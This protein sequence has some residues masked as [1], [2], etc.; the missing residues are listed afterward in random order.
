MNL[1]ADQNLY[2]ERIAGDIKDTVTTTG[3]GGAI[4]AF[5]NGVSAYDVTMKAFQLALLVLMVLHVAL[6][7]IK[8]YADWQDYRAAGGTLFGGSRVPTGTKA[9]GAASKKGPRS[10]DQ[11]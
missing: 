8:A 11:D 3:A 4:L 7:V 10:P 9:G 6:R 5:V 1:G 2:M